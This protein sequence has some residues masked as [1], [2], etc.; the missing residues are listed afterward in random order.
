MVRPVNQPALQFAIIHGETY[1]SY[2][3]LTIDLEKKTFVISSGAD[4]S[5]ESNPCRQSHPFGVHRF[6]RYRFAVQIFTHGAE[7]GQHD[8]DIKVPK[9]RQDGHYVDWQAPDT[10]SPKVFMTVF[11]DSL[12]LPRSIYWREFYGG[13]R[14]PVLFFQAQHANSRRLVAVELG[15]TN[16]VRGPRESYVTGGD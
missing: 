10:K 8:Q 2:R 3:E 14:Y 12:V 6:S 4:C 5:C 7:N 1:S 16:P 13:I 15:P 11:L 9:C